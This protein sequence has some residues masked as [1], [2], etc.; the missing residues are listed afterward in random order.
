MKIL[1]DRCIPKRLARLLIGHLPTHASEVEWG[2]EPNGKLVASA[3]VEGFEVILTVDKRMPQE[4]S[5][6]GL[7]IGGLV[8]DVP[9][10]TLE[11]LIKALPDV[12][13]ELPNLKAGSY[14]IVRPDLWR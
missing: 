11:T 9:D 5:L 4:T 3:A 7:P 6:Q 13:S 2:G 1:L 8:I 14:L 10:N 12:L